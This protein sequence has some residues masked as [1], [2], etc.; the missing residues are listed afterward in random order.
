MLV[1]ICRDLNLGLLLIL[2]LVVIHQL[3]L[4]LHLP[5]SYPYID[6]IF[7]FTPSFFK[8]PLIALFYL[9]PILMEISQVNLFY[10]FS[11]RNYDEQSRTIRQR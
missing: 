5:V 6:Y 4:F 3:M 2:C 8:S 1:S 7:E 10:K 11:N 9:L